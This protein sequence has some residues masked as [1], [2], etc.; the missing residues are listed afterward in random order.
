MEIDQRALSVE[1]KRLVLLIA[2]YCDAEIY[3]PS[4]KELMTNLHRSF[5]H[6]DKGLRLLEKL[7]YLKIAWGR[8]APAG[9]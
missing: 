3:D 5:T 8:Q 6:V 1:L 7:G 9:T 4:F 2:G